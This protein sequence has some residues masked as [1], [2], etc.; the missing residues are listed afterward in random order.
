MKSL[1][2]DI[3]ASAS[4]VILFVV[5]LIFLGIIYGIFYYFIGE[6]AT[7]ESTMDLLMWRAYVIT[8]VIMFVGLSGWLIMRGQKK[9]SD[10]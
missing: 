7:I 8:I 4:P 3:V 2:S 6:T 5:L 9:G 10:L 1:T